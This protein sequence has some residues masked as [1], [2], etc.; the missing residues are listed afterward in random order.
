MVG[1]EWRLE[2]GG[3][4]WGM[5]VSGGWLGGV[6]LIDVKIVIL[7]HDQSIKRTW[8]MQIASSK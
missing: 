6:L 4:G 2:W 3:V 5:G 1:V 7:S 8:M